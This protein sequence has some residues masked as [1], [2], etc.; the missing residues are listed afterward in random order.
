M[1]QKIYILNNGEVEFILKIM[2][3]CAYK[4]VHLFRSMVKY[5]GNIILQ[6]HK[7]QSR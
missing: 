1:A 2:E 7:I 3:V 5:G 6:S 4:N